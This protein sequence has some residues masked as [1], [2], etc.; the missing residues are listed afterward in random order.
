MGVP[1]FTLFNAQNLCARG[2]VIVSFRN[3]YGFGYGNV[4]EFFC[5]EGEVYEI[6]SL[7]GGGIININTPTFYATEA[8][9]EV[10]PAYPFPFPIIPG[11]SSKFPSASI[12]I[13]SELPLPSTNLSPSAPSKLS[14]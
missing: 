1:D 10:F 11:P 14:I 13:R 4:G 6:L 2:T 5:Y 8:A 7:G 3:N 9:A 12:L